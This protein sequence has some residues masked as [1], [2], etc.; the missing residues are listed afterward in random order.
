[1]KLEDA[2]RE[3]LLA[4]IAAQ[5]TTIIHLEGRV[6][7]LEARLGKGGPKGMAG[8][9]PK[10]ASP[11]QPQKARK[12]RQHGFARVR[13]T[14]TQIVTHGSDAC[15]DCGTHLEG[16]SVKRRR[17]VIELPVQPVQVVEHVF[18]ERR[19]P[20]CD[21]QV[22]PQDA[23]TGVVVGKQ[24]LGIG[25]VSLI[26]VLREEG[27]LPDR[28]IQ[29]YL[30]TFHKLKLSLGAIVEAAKSLA[31][32]GQQ[33]VE[34][35]RQQV[36]CSPV[37][38]ADETG[39]RENGVNGYVW[40]FSTPSERYFLRGNRSGKVVDEV[41]GEKFSGV[42][43]S[44]FYAAYNHYP[45]LH[46]RCWVHLLRDIKGLLQL[47]PEDEGLK[48]WAEGVRKVYEEAKLFSHPEEEGRLRAQQHFEGELLALC[49][50]FVKDHTAAQRKLCLRIQRFLQELFV[51]VGHPAVPSD[52]NGAERSLRHI[53]TSRKISGGTRSKAGSDTKTTLATLF[54]TWRARNLDPLL[55]C[56]Q[57]LFSPQL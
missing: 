30:R 6:R 32:M 37:V 45:G 46:Q 1:M 38:N 23:L 35:I 13:S 52:N 26:T 55:A 2:S 17:E 31:R 8:L 16:G 29:W 54:G 22:A 40:T 7:D 49:Q 3:E 18:I 28:T 51:F 19:C 4:V 57:L 27:R 53:V 25:L 39:W 47:Y 34:E 21:K 42:L 50:P 41:L 15:P 10:S 43:V 24:R 36:R 33:A 20:V 9:K 44:D 48:E 56:R 12:P 5:E 11:S 14:P